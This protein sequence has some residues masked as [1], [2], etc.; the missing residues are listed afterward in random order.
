MADTLV[1]LC[2]L[3]LRAALATLGP[4]FERQSGCRLDLR[5]ESSNAL[6]QRIAAG[7]RADLAILVDTAL[8]TLA[9]E[10]KTD[11]RVDLVLSRVGI[12]VR[13]G[14]TKPDIGTVDAF[15]DTLCAAQS[16]AY[17]RTGASG[18]HFAR[19][20]ERLG[21]SNE[22]NAKAR[23]QDGFTGE[24]AARGEAELAVQQLSELA[25]VDGIDIVGPIPEELQQVTTFSAAI[26][27][28]AEQPAAAQALI[29]FLAS[30]AAAPALRASG[31]EPVNA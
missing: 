19:V 14:A 12:A 23:V 5:F 6:M 4:E 25:A 13:A 17:T 15:V 7:E 20:L 1:V 2:T 3:G 16:V 29:T 27:S 28:H 24:L 11:A 31:L 18:I 21:I 10:G 22:I 26:F 30:A 9:R 8:Q